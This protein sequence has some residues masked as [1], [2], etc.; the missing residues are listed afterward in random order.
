ML[1]CGQTLHVHGEKTGWFADYWEDFNRVISPMK[2]KSGQAATQAHT[3]G[4]EE[5]AAMYGLWSM[6]APVIL[7]PGYFVFF[8][9]RR[10][11]VVMT[12][13]I[14]VHVLVLEL[15]TV[16]QLALQCLFVEA[17]LVAYAPCD[18]GQIVTICR[19]CT[20]YN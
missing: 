8:T 19:P 12:L 7:D 11:S 1:T 14:E 18:V 3:A 15:V 16:P 5:M 10:V 6:L 13:Y 2:A 20:R 4:V 9:G 17:P